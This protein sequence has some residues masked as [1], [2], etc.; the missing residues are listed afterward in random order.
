MFSGV[1]VKI[2]GFTREED[3][4]AAIAAGVWAVGFVCWPASPRAV[5]PDRL[6]A[7]TADV[8]E[9]VRRVAVMVD[10]TL[11]NARRVRDE[12]NISVVQLHGNED[13]LQFL[14]LGLDVIKAVSL[15]SDAAVD[16]AAA[17]PE[18]VIVLVDAHDPARRGGTGAHADWVRASALAACRPIILAGGLRADNI[19]QAI[20]QVGPW[21]VDVSSGVESSPGIKDAALISSLMKH[22]Q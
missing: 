8:P 18:E 9:D 4:A 11:E 6:R 12:S 10:A 5:T 7:L 13:P 3:V 16:R 19:R 1:H 20:D 15:D 22:A 21:G 17:L 2:C 14:S